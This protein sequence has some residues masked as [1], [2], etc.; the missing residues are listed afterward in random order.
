MKI[1]V[2]DI[3]ASTG[4]AL[5]ILKD[6]YSY[7]KEHDKINEWI[8]LLSDR[9]LEETDRIKVDILPEIKKNR[10][11]KLLFDHITGKKVIESYH[12]DAVLSLQNTAIMGLK[13][14]QIVYVHQSIPFQDIVRFSFLKKEE[15]SLAIY[16]Y[17]I[18]GVIKHSIKKC[19]KVIVQTEWMK[20]AAA[21]KTG[22]SS[23]D[24]C[25][26]PPAINIDV[27]V[28]EYHWSN[29]QFFYPSSDAVY[30]NVRCIN[31]AVNL[32]EQRG[33]HPE[34]SVTILSE[35]Y[36]KIHCIGP[37]LREEVMQKYQKSTLVF[38]SYI[39]SCPLPLKEA[40][41]SGTL[42][43]AS[44]CPFSHE[45][46]DGYENAY[47][48]DP[49]KPEELSKL[50]EDVMSGKIIKKEAEY[51]D[52]TIKRGWEQVLSVIEEIK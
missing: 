35:K 5:S 37:I 30:K 45:I 28:E 3:A 16:Q 32:L 29:D 31:Q 24:I 46:L 10:W 48:F 41:K 47:F 42:I 6:F 21:E 9:Y 19:D 4:G 27:P 15:R 34:V 36:D 11:K 12:P 26:I 13:V 1:V 44:D 7:V 38:P 22:K 25:V 20:K 18:G 49:F 51:D 14:P 52:D 23:S 39:E 40:K 33:H 8:F 43:L 17:L 2:I 50:M